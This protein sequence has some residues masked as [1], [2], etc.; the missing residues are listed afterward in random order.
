MQIKSKQRVKERGEVFTSTREVNN[1][2]DLLPN[3]TID[4]TFLEPTCGNGAFVVEILRRKFNLCKKKIDYIT[5][6]KSMYAID[7]MT[8]NI[9]ECKQRVKELYNSYNQ[10]ENIDF[11]LDTNIFQGNSLAIMKLLEDKVIYCGSRKGV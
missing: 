5:A 4:T 3:I 2:L 11:I 10:K 6:L 7:I 9:K 8:D 1:M